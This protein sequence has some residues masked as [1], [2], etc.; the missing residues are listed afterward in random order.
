MDFLKIVG[1]DALINSF[2]INCKDK[3]TGKPQQNIQLV[4]ELQDL[5]FN[6]LTSSVG[7]DTKRVKMFLTTSKLEFSNYGTAVQQLKERLNLPTENKDD[8]LGFLRNTCMEPYQASEAYVEHLGNLF[9]N[10][11]LTC[12]GAVSIFLNPLSGNVGYIRHDTVVTSDSCNS[13][14][15]ENYEKI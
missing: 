13:G 3:T 12:I 8:A 5:I 15:S 4:N 11:V 10:T 9:R 7:E 2:T 6:E 1:P 14:H